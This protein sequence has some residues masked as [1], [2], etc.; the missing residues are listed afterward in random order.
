MELGQRWILFGTG[1]MVVIINSLVV[2][3]KDSKIDFEAWLTD[4]LPQLAKTC[5]AD[6]GTMLS[7][8]WKPGLIVK[9]I[10]QYISVTLQCCL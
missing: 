3:C 2:T 8:L 7:L 9:S 10:Q 1:E 6:I 5:A 4:T